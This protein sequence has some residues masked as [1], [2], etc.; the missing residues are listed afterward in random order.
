MLALLELAL[1]MPPAPPVPLALLDPLA[2]PAPPA[3]PAPLE[4]DPLLVVDPLL[5]DDDEELLLAPPSGVYGVQ[6]APASVI[7]QIAGASQVFDVV[8]QALL[9]HWVSFSHAW[10]AMPHW[11]KVFTPAMH[12]PVV[13]GS[14]RS[15]IVALSADGIRH[16]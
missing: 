2:P 11:L 14:V 3:P 7:P 5:V 13:D 16:L 1:L 8:L 4:L 15:T 9:Q 10:P 6:G 12:T